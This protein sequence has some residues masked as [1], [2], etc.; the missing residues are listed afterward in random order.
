MELH[1][2]VCNY[3][4]ICTKGDFLS[5]QADGRGSVWRLRTISTKESFKRNKNDGTC[6]YLWIRLYRPCGMRPHR[7]DRLYVYCVKEAS[8]SS[9]PVSV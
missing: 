4:I 7:V 3:D 1:V 2:A 8:S 6:L 9:A 5:A